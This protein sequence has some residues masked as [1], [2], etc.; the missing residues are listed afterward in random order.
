MTQGQK[1]DGRKAYLSIIRGTRG[2]QGL[3]GVVTRKDEAGNVD[4]ELASDVEE[5][6]E[7]VNTDQTQDDIDLGNGGLSL[8]VVQDRVLRQL[9]RTSAEGT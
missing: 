4:K 3:E 7:E 1:G 8:H 2:E 9:P 6:E 5:D